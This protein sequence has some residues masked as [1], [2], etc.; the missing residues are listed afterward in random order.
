MINTTEKRDINSSSK[1]RKIPKNNTNYF[2]N[3]K[4]DTSIDKRELKLDKN[5]INSKNDKLANN[6]DISNISFNS[7]NIS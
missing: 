2:K 6:K 4:I 3:N 1:N 7:N 5:P